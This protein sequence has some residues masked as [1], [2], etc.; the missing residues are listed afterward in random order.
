LLGVWKMES[1]C[2]YAGN[3]Y[4]QLNLPKIRKS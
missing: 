1:Q 2:K 4:S 3:Q